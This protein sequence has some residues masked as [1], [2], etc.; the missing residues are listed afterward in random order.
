MV[1]RQ[2]H[3]RWSYTIPTGHL[4]RG[5]LHRQLRGSR[6]LR[7]ILHGFVLHVHAHNF[8]LNSK[9]FLHA[10]LFAGL[11]THWHLTGSHWLLNGQ[12]A[13]GFIHWQL[14]CSLEYRCVSLSQSVG[15][16]AH[17]HEQSVWFVTLTTVNSFDMSFSLSVEDD[18]DILLT[19]RLK[20]F[21]TTG[22]EKLS[23]QLALFSAGGT[24]LWPHWWEAS[25]RTTAPFLIPL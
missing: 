17:W 1:P 18:Q 3:E 6:T 25:A 13:R 21:V 15:F 8:S 5:H 12:G 7:S 19:T 20:S 9:R 22:E 23:K 14:Q 10:N 4:K 11:H 16:I 2:V 24:R